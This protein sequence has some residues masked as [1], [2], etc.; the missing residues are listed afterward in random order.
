MIDWENRTAR[1][2]VQTIGQAA[3]FVAAGFSL[4]F[5]VTQIVP[6]WCIW[7]L[8]IGGVTFAFYVIGQLF[9]AARKLVLWLRASS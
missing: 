8:I 1:K 2:I 5:L 3:V 7:F 9:T 6:V 4:Y